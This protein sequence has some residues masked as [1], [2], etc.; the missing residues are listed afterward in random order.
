MNITKDELIDIIA[1]ASY[2]LHLEIKNSHSNGTLN[3]YLL[4][5][6][7]EDLIPKDEEPL[8]ESVPYGKVLIFGDSKINTNIIYGC[9][10]Q[11]NIEKDRV[12]L[13]L[14][15]EKA[16]KYPFQKL[17]YNSSYRLIM[18][19]PVPHSGTGKDESSS[20]I[21]NIENR[22]GYPKVVRLTDG[23]GLKITKSNLKKAIKKEVD[24]KYLAV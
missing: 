13:H 19:G 2:R 10:K 7:M 6:G 11:F 14:G 23:H 24:C 21:T 18:F 15:Y 22:E 4:N 12:E 1:E 9:F 17:Q 3:N 16:S 20:I 8:Y 5:I